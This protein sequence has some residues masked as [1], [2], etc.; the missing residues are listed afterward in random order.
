MVTW[1]WSKNPVSPRSPNA[2]VQG[3][4][5]QTGAL[6]SCVSVSLVTWR[7]TIAM[8]AETNEPPTAS[9]VSRD[10]VVSIPQSSATWAPKRIA[11]APVSS[12]QA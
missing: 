5:N 8:R 7:L 1:N 4:Q 2:G 9:F 10:F 11:V 6:H 12:R 3:S